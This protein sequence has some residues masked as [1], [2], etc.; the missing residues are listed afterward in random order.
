MPPYTAF[1]N[2]HLYW[3][4]VRTST[5]LQVSDIRRL[6]ELG[7]AT[8]HKHVRVKKRRKSVSNHIEYTQY[9]LFQCS[10]TK[11]SGNPVIMTKYS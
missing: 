7:N 2:V 9:S 10:L 11:D 8:I 4:V 6:H 3:E 5:I 1:S